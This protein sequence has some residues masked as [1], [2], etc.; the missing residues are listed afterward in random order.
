MQSV[1]VYYNNTCYVS[2]H[3]DL[4]H[5]NRGHYLGNSLL[6]LFLHDNHKAVTARKRVL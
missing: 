5:D 2:A 3:V 6:T 1:N 4:Q